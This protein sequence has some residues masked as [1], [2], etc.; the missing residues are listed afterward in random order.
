MR[1][2]ERGE[3]LRVR[4]LAFDRAAGEARLDELLETVA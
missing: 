1:R 2:L 4:P 3:A